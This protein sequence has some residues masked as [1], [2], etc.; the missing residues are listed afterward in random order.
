MAS[1]QK[2]RPPA[3]A[4]NMFSAGKQ[5][6]DMTHIVLE[7]VADLC[8]LPFRLVSHAALDLG[9]VA[10]AIDDWD[11]PRDIDLGGVERQGISYMDEELEKKLELQ[12]AQ[13][14]FASC[15]VAEADTEATVQEAHSILARL[16]ELLDFIPP[17]DLATSVDEL[18][19]IER[20]TTKL[21]DDSHTVADL[22]PDALLKQEHPL[23]TPRVETFMLLQMMVYSAYQ[24]SGLQHPLSLVSVA[25][26]HF[27]AT[28]DEQLTVLRKIL[29]GLSRSGTSKNEAQWLADRAKLVWLW[30]WGIEA[31]AAGVL[32]KIS[33]ADF[34][35]E[36]LKVFTET[37]C[38]LFT[39]LVAAQTPSHFILPFDLR[40]IPAQKIV[41]V[42]KDGLEE[43]ELLFPYV[44]ES[45]PG[46]DR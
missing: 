5:S 28:R 37:S 31:D 40:P 6:L 24:F 18:P 45:Q 25:K 43:G 34:E 17:P 46:V 2:T 21:N 3:T 16:A 7:A 27:Y 19:K 9:L 42:E 44:P 1:K 10:R 14:A 23:T 12:Y 22:L 4:G 32:N 11:G 26:L 30:N 41:H 36:M 8:P 33:Q 15:Y 35:E 20:H 39:N 13:A 29:R 38:K